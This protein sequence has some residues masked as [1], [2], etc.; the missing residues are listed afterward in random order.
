MTSLLAR[1]KGKEK[2]KKQWIEERDQLMRAARIVEIDAV[3][4]KR[5]LEDRVKDTKSQ[6]KK[7]SRRVFDV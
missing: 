1:L 5:D 2:R 6:C 4:M 7:T 3:R